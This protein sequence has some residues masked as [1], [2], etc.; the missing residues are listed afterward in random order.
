VTPEQLEEARQV[1]DGEA[2]YCLGCGKVFPMAELTN[3]MACSYLCWPCAERIEA[4][5]AAL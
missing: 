1:H 2:A 4:E 5:I 3:A